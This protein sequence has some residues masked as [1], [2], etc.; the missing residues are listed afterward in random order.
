MDRT[1]SYL[2]AVIIDVVVGSSPFLGLSPYETL[3]IILLGS[4]IYSL[5]LTDLSV[6]L[7]ASLVPFTLFSHT[8]FFLAISSLSIALS[9][10]LRDKATAFLLALG[11]SL[12]VFDL[13]A[14]YQVLGFIVLVGILVYLKVDLR[15]IVANGIF[16]LLIAS[17]VA[18]SQGI[19]SATVNVLS[20]GAYYSLFFGVLGLVLEN[21]RLPRRFPRIPLLFV[22][23]ALVVLG[24]GIPSEY[25]WWS[26]SSFVF[27][28]NP[29]SL[30]VPVIYFPQVNQILGSWPLAHVLIHLPLGVNVYMALLT[31]ISGVGS[32]VMFKKLGVRQVTLFSLVYQVLSPFPHPYLLLGYAILPFTVY[33]MSLNARKSVKYSAIM[34]TSVVGS[35]FPLFPVSAIAMGA[36]LRRKD[37]P[38]IGV[39]IV[40]ANAFWIIPYLVLGGPSLGEISSSLTLALLLPV[41]VVAAK[42]EDKVKVLTA[43]GSLAY[44]VSGLPYSELAYPVAIMSSL[45]LVSGEGVKKVLAGVTISLLLITAVFQ[46]GSYHAVTIPPTIQ[47][48]SKE[49]ENA[50]LVWWNYSY[51][52][53]SPVPFNTSPVVTQGIQYIVNSQGKV[54]PNP[55]YTGFPVFF[56]VI[57]PNNLSRANGTWI[58]E[59]YPLLT[60]NS[61]HFLWNYKSDGLLVN[62]SQGVL[63]K[64]EIGVQFIAWRIPNNESSLLVSLNGSW[65]SYFGEPMLFLG[66]NVSNQSSVTP[67]N[68]TALTLWL[69]NGGQ[70]LLYSKGTHE[71]PRGYPIPTS[72]SFSLNFY[73]EK[74]GNFTFL[75]GE[76]IDGEFH[77]LDINTTLPWNE[78]NSLGLILPLRNELNLSQIQV[79]SFVPVNITQNWI[80]WNSS[81]PFQV[82]FYPSTALNGTLYYKST[83]SSISVEIN[84]VPAENGSSFTKVSNSTLISG[85][86]PV[87]VSALYFTHNKSVTY[88]VG[89]LPVNT[90]YQVKVK[91]LI[92]GEELIVSSHLPLNMT[93]IP[94]KGI[95]YKVDGSPFKGPVTELSPG[96]HV[97]QIVYPGEVFLIPSFYVSVLSFAIALLSERIGEG[98]NEI[99]RF[100]GIIL[101]KIES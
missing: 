98:L 36:F 35:S 31:Y 54:L 20:D 73:L 72:G 42:L 4:A 44:L 32:Y 46:V 22:P 15:G 27:R 71:L 91:Q 76:A 62:V 78:I 51:P 52:L 74:Q 37:L 24:L 69:T 99:R 3:A 33:L 18:I 6:S 80:Y 23:Y 61:S 47:K 57:L 12:L 60:L 38:W 34:L 101:N 14:G 92:G 41:L 2:I 65:I 64:S 7:P 45:L 88:V 5:I 55:N 95:G 96:T 28:A 53:L 26:E 10:Y 13:N 8:Y 25:Y 66:Y 93:I 70:V 49:V 50:T 29:L 97:I 84:E 81:K 100:A 19:D 86:G 77:P 56:K 30:W 39:A 11:V 87:N 82:T 63:I 1:L 40:G 9:F 59:V 83:S 90:T 85:P 79:S 94:I 75:S 89:A 17:V 16:L 68:F 48:I 43:L 21:A 58:P 67:I